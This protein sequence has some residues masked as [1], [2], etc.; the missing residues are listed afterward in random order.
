M[1]NCTPASKENTQEEKEEMER[2]EDMVVQDEAK[3]D[4]IKQELFKEQ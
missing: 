4:S 1:F 3:L 2:V